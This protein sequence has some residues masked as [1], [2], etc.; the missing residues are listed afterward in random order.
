M[1]YST[2]S[3]RRPK[4]EF[5]FPKALVRAGARGGS[6]S[7]VSPS[8][9][10][11]S[12][13]SRAGRLFFIEALSAFPPTAHPGRATARDPPGRRE[14]RWTVLAGLPSR[15]GYSALHP[16]GYRL[17]YSLPCQA[18]TRPHSETTLDNDPTC[19]I[20]GCNSLICVSPLASLGLAG[21]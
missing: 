8:L 6:R 12:R 2:L 13:A 14:A 4:Q 9:G 18:L 7:R 5:I 15:D 17:A 1:R 3:T 19:Q 10:S 21:L 16:T 20:R 11:L